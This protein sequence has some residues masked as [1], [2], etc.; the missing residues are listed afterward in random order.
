MDGIL[1]IDKPQGQTSFSIVVM[2]RQL[3]GEK[4]VGHA[5]TLDPLATGVLP[6]CLGQGTRVVEFLHDM[7]KVYQAEIEL[8]VVTET[9][10]ASGRIIQK[11]DPSGIS[12]S[13]LES[14]LP[15]FCGEI[16]QVPPIYSAVKYQGRP[17]YEL[18][19]AGVTVEPRSRL[20]KI[21]KLELLD[22]SPPVVT[23]EVVCGKGTYIRSLAHDLGQTLGCGANLKGL[24]RLRY[25][26]FDRRDAISVAQL[27]DAFRYG[28]W[29]NL[30]YSID[31]ALPHW[32]AMVLSDEAEQC[33]RNGRPLV[34]K[35]PSV[36]NRC[37]AYSNDGYFLGVLC[38]DADKGQWRPEKVFWS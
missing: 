36:E 22:F 17:L 3:S 9:Y 16:R 26:L 34:L 4:R 25:G 29:R 32:T 10:D 18:A 6:I 5:G 12:R 20:V 21:Y 35:V 15:F 11:K 37:R 30:V 13:R 23:V 38:F 19:R 27:E 14:I 33:V 24:I 31:S 28:Y 1:N 2:V 8:G 7:N